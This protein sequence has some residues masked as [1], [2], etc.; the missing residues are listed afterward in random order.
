MSVVA[1]IQA[2]MGSSRLPGKS[3]TDICGKP[4]IARV[5]ERVLAA[6]KVDRV[7][8]ATTTAATDDPLRDY[9]AGLGLPVVR[10]PEIDVLG[11]YARA[12]VELDARVVVRITGDDPLKAPEVIDRVVGAFL[13]G[14][15][16]AYACNNAPPT[17]PEGL[18]VEVMTFDAL[19]AA[20]A[21]ATEASDREHVTPFLRQRPDR[22][23]SIN[24][25]WGTDLSSHR[26]TL[27]TEDDL[28]FFR[29]VF[30]EMGDGILPWRDVLK[31]LQDRPALRAL[32]ASVARSS[33][34]T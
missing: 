33:L 29:A 5:A 25:A 9:I 23:P 11:R 19:R 27:D 3:L 18:D 1:I 6:R 32:N 7:A 30:A 28:A 12:A 16:V 22:F 10:G 24:V 2:R 26:W 17:F 14:D 13:D 4:L 8:V 21:E 20:D 34:Y 15:P 31:L